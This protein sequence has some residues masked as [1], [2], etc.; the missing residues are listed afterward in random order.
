MDIHRSMTTSFKEPCVDVRLDPF[1]RLSA[2]THEGLLNTILSQFRI[3]MKQL[4]RISQQRTLQPIEDRSQPRGTVSRRAVS[5][6]AVSGCAVQR[7]RGWLEGLG[8]QA[9]GHRFRW[10]VASQMDL[11]NCKWDKVP[12]S[13]RRNR[14]DFIRAFSKKGSRNPATASR[15]WN[16]V[17][18]SG[19]KA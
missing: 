5:G 17:H 7:F 6:C 19:S 8:D 13:G 10:I 2:Q 14:S 4:A 16:F 3:P 15:P 1:A 9:S 12:T 11:V 18:F